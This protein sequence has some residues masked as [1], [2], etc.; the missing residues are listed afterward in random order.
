MT[1]PAESTD[2]RDHPGPG[3]DPGRPPIAFSTLACPEWSPGE[4]VDRAATLG[5]DAIEWRG[6]PDGHVRTDWPL[7]RRR[8]LARHAGDRGI[9][10]LAV[11]AYTSFLD[12][13]AAARQTS[14][15]DLARHLEL[16]ADLGAAA[17]RVF[18]GVA[19]DRAPMTELVERAVDSVS[20]VIGA[21]RS[22]GVTMAIEPHD[23][24]VRSTIVAPILDTIDDP[25]VGAVWDIAN[26]WSV[27]ESPETGVAI[28]GPRIRYVQVKDGRGQGE[29]WQLTEI[30]AGEVPLA[31]ALALLARTRRLP[32]VSFEWE[33]A[34]H[35]ELPSA[36]RVLG[37][38]LGRIR[39]LID[40]A[41]RGKA[42]RPGRTG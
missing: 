8:E 40:D 35:P 22:T 1:F 15:D 41:L 16:A 26:A 39:A 12:A 32:P 21:A 19:T 7:H 24:F 13:D 11:T 31:E 6:G 34:W 36:D 42:A 33:R 9:R 5:Y 23:E 29:T 30:G 38:A 14:A 25:A 37:P 28:L 2:Q 4:I 27:G 10:A 20:S 3:P 17:V 18:V